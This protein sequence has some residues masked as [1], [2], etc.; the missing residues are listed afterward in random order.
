[1]QEEYLAK[2]KAKV[3]GKFKE[4]LKEIQMKIERE[5][6]GRDLG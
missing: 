1:M 3:E 4:K 2:E 5:M 6:A